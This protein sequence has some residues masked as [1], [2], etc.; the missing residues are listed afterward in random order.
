MMALYLDVHV[1]AAIGAELRRRGVD[2]FTVQENGAAT[3]ED[4]AL[5]NG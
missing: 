4:G 1:P 5:L 2:I 3:M